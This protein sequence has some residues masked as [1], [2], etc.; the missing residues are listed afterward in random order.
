M[1]NKIE[2][3]NVPVYHVYA[4]AL[5]PWEYGAQPYDIYVVKKLAKK[6]ASSYVFAS[7][8][9]LTQA[10]LLRLC[11]PNKEIAPSFETHC[12]EGDQGTAVELIC[13]AMRNHL[14]KYIDDLQK[15]RTSMISPKIINRERLAD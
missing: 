4:A 13:Q 8:K 9:M 7:G 11:N 5:M 2:D 15:M 10:K 12:L 6:K 1:L 3:Y 14:D